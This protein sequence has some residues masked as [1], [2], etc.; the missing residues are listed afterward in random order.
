[1]PGP[2]SDLPDREM[3]A[4]TQVVDDGGAHRT[5][6]RP[7]P[8]TGGFVI[9]DATPADNADLIALSAACAMT[10]DIELRIDRHPEFFALNRLEGQ[11]WRVGVAELMG[12]VVGC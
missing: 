4:L 7:S 8:D 3:T 1:P 10:G 9:R 5:G 6:I 12:R 2:N 11:R